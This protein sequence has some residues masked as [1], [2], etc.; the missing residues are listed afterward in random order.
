MMIK[1]AVN[2]SDDDVVIF[3][4]SGT[5]GAIHKLIGVLELKEGGENTV[6]QFLI[7]QLHNNWTVDFLSV[8]SGFYEEVG[9]YF[10]TANFTIAFSSIT[11]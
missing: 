11:Q 5:T 2:A 1:R 8:L 7:R 9:L 10:N 6:R 3:T 4:G